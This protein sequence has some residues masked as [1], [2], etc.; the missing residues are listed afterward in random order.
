MTNW[1]SRELELPLTFLGPG[2][3]TAEIYADAP[4]AAQ[5]PKSICATKKPVD[6]NSRLSIKLAP[7]GG[8]AVRFAPVK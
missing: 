7:G 2:R 1:N 3:Y 8:Y 6:R 5:Y 4:N